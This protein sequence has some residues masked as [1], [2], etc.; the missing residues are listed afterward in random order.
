MLRLMYRQLLN[1]RP[2]EVDTLLA[3]CISNPGYKNVYIKTLQSQ[4]F[5]FVQVPTLL[6]NG[7]RKHM[8]KFSLRRSVSSL[9]RPVESAKNVMLLNKRYS[10]VEKLI[11]DAEIRNK[12]MEIIRNGSALTKNDVD[13]IY[14]NFLKAIDIVSGFPTSESIDL[15]LNMWKFVFQTDTSNKNVKELQHKFLNKRQPFITILIN[16]KNYSFYKDIVEPLYSIRE[17]KN[18]KSTWS[19]RLANTFQFDIDD[20][21]HIIFNKGDWEP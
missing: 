3:W 9:G 14:A 4:I 19:D 7:L 21:G 15:L 10:E 8:L 1:Q 12:Y 11:S 16:T 18:H 2:S 17:F 13:M 5:P 6:K 20:K